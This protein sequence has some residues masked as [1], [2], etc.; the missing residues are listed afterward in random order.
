MHYQ[1]SYA[2]GH[3]ET[4]LYNQQGELTEAAACNVYVIKHGIVATPL[5]DHQKLPGITRQM[6]LEIL[7]RDGSIAIQELSLI[8]I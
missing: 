7:R 5:L 8:H 6:L 1:Q 4:L 2:R 3:S